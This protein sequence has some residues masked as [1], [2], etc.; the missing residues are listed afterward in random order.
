MKDTYKIL[1]HSFSMALER[2]WQDQSVLRITG[3]ELDGLVHHINVTVDSSN[4]SIDL[5]EYAGLYMQ[6]LRTSLQGF[7]L[8]TF[9]QAKMFNKQVAVEAVYQW[10]TQGRG[11]I[12][13]R[14]LF[15]YKNKQIYTLMT[16]FTPQTWRKLHNTIDNMMRSFH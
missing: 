10:T 6:N 4:T 14:C 11:R 1:K 5:Q 12:I 9:A 3:P 2:D 7:K 8:T 13:Q 16:T 15:T